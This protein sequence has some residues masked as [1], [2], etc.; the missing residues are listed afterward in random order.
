MKF[1]T[2]AAC[3]LV[4][5]FLLGAI[6]L[7]QSDTFAGDWVVR[8]YKVGGVPDRGDLTDWV[9]ITTDGNYYYVS[10]LD[11]RAEHMSFVRR[12]NTLE[13]RW[14]ADLAYLKEHYDGFPES[15]LVQANHQVEYHTVISFDG[16]G[17]TARSSNAS[18]N[19]DQSGRYRGYQP[20][21][22]YYYWYLTRPK[23]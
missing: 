5:M 16:Q 22:G 13:G 10:G 21:E 17:I 6:A 3:S 19:Y 8:D 9:K 2:T 15:V 11:A 4:S 18:I 23:Q 12:G 7:G 1:K 20:V 14:V